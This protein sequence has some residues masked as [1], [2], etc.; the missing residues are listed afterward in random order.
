MSRGTRSR[1]R[2]RA[3]GRSSSDAMR[4]PVSMVPPC[5]RRCAASAR[6]TLPAPPRTIGQPTACA[7]MA[8]TIPVL[9]LAALFSDMI[10]CAAIPA[11]S[12]RPLPPRDAT[13]ARMLAGRRAGAP[14]AATRSGWRGGR[15][16]PRNWSRISSSWRVA[17]DSRRRYVPASPPSPAAVAVMERSSSTA[18]SP[19][20]GW[21]IGTAGWTTSSPYRSAGN[22]RKNREEVAKGMTDAPTSWRKPGRVSSAVRHAPPTSSAASTT[23]TARPRSASTMAAASPLGPEPTTTAS[24]GRVTAPARSDRPSSAAEAWEEGDGCPDGTGQLALFARPVAR[25]ASV[26]TP[27]TSVVVDGGDV[28]PVGGVTVHDA[29]RPKV[30]EVEVEPPPLDEGAPPEERSHRRE[31]AARCGQPGVRG[32]VDGVDAVA[33][34]GV[35]VV[36]G[37]LHKGAVVEEDHEW[38]AAQPRLQA[39]VLLDGGEV[40]PVTATVQPQLLKVGGTARL[41]RLRRLDTATPLEDGEQEEVVVA[42]DGAAVTPSPG[43]ARGRGA[44]AAPREAALEEIAEEHCVDVVLRVGVERLLEALDVALHIADNEEGSGHQPRIALSPSASPR[45]HAHPQPRGAG[46]GP[47][48]RRHPPPWRRGEAEGLR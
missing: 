13:R 3:A 47:A 35:H 8:M 39:R 31:H 43:E 16:G 25:E 23:C 33:E 46:P 34:A 17:A 9:E 44:A 1:R 32:G 20:S 29:P 24:S 40:G 6:G 26:E 38:Q 21:A 28:L 19:S 5:A 10:E 36:V 12:A 18:S 15:S 4:R 27:E 7:T 45:R 11:N 41:P 2:M 37:V 42:E 14:K 48:A 22:S 30:V